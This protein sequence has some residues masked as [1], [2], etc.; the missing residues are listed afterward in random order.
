MKIFDKRPLCLILC[1]MLG[2]FVF[3]AHHLLPAIA[4]CALLLL[5]SLVVRLPRLR[6]RLLTISVCLIASTL[7]SGVY[8]VL[9][10]HAYDRFDGEVN[11]SGTVV[12]WEQSEFYDRFY[13]KTDDVNGE[14]FSKYN[15]ILDIPRTERGTLHPGCE[16]EISAE[17][18][19]FGESDGFDIKS[20]YFS[21]GIN[22]VI[23]D[24][25]GL[26]ITKMGPTPLPQ[27]FE[28]MRMRVQRHAILLS[29]R[30]AGTLLTA[31][32]LGERDTLSDQL[33][34][35]FTRMG[36]NHILALSGM[37]LSIL[38]L[39]ISF[40]LRALR[41]GRRP[42]TVI[43][44]IFVLA[45]MAFTGFS[46]SV[47]RSGVMFILASL[48]YLAKRGADAITSLSV[49]VFV[50]CLTTP[51]A[52][53]ST[54]LWLSAFATLGVLI[55]AEYSDS[56]PRPKNIP[57]RIVR[58]MGISML[59]SVF[60]I[61]MT[62]HITLFKFYGTSSISIITTLVFSA[63]A[64][65]IMYL[66]TLMLIFDRLTPFL[67]TVLGAI[68]DAVFWLAS[69]ISDFDFAYASA[70]HSSLRITAIVLT[71]LF[72][73]FITLRIKRKHVAVILLSTIFATII[74][75]TVYF[76]YADD[77]A[78][79][80]SYFSCD[81]SD[82]LL[83]QSEDECTFI[84]SATYSKNLAYANVDTLRSQNVTRIDR[85]VLTHYARSLDD[86]LEVLC[87]NFLV[88]NLFIPSPRN[89][90]EVDILR[91][92]ERSLADFRCNIVTYELLDPV[93]LGDA[94][95]T[96]LYSTPYG[97]GTSVNALYLDL[98]DEGIAYLSSGVLELKA[99]EVEAIKD[100]MSRATIHIY[101]RHGKKYKKKIFFGTKDFELTTLVLNNVYL[102]QSSLKEYEKSGCTV[103][104]HPLS[105]K[106]K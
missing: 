48:L 83:I 51:Y 50:I 18:E 90:E 66:G 39:G 37:H 22:G 73:C 5:F 42:R 24:H 32:L 93:E 78:E 55:A 34:L 2:G 98:C 105:L 91:I 29:D 79:G 94:A 8:F 47:V 77:S 63:L 61:T 106:L 19:D 58:H 1:I 15:L 82:T 86:D 46:V 69:K 40:A 21:R 95:L 102:T 75:Q 56:I 71:V 52:I 76:A 9:W 14:P 85:Y 96:L 99:V 89:E 49:A 13:V 41:I 100:Y 104:A 6:A 20:Y 25:T 33:R 59:A 60:A 28:D 97:E 10:F 31:L 62:L 36:I 16:I 12:T 64:E 30:D 88:D 44:I 7:F 23:S 84:N 72:V 80:V 26:K 92:I 35:D 67:G 74:G 87:S 103:H 57:L 4:I 70:R 65:A 17:I 43:L 45:Y 53:F 54:A 27:R 68:T 3:S 11:I 101:G 38:A 81:K